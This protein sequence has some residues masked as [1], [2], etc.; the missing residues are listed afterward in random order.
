VTL[1][2]YE[3]TEKDGRVLIGAMDAVSEAEVRTRLTEK[4]YRVNAVYSNAP[5]AA[6]RSQAVPRPQAI[7]TSG[8][9]APFGELSVFF[10]G[11]ASYLHSG[12]VLHQALVQIGAQTPNRGMKII[13]DRMAARIQAGQRLSEAMSEFPRAFPPHV[14]G[15]TAAGELAGFLPIMIGDIAFNYELEQKASK[16][17]FAYVCKLGWINAIGT[18]IVSPILPFMAVVGVMDV[19]SMLT[20]YIRWTVPHI[21]L[22]IG[23]AFIIYYTA[24]IVLRQPGMRPLA[25]SLVLRVPAYGRASKE[26]SLAGFSRI[27]WRL[28]NAGILP[29]AAWDTASRAAENVVVAERLHSQLDAIRQGRKFSDALAATGMF[30][31]EDQRVLAMGE[32]AGQ[33]ADILKRIADF[34]EDSAMTSFGRSRWFATKIVI[35]VNVLAFA[36]SAVCLIQYLKNVFTWVDWFMGTG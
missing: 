33:T 35:W 30:T 6:P 36:F 11:L 20:K 18:I 25:H 12:V 2:K 19:Q 17:W 8:V 10:R 15:L 31:S 5:A 22:P 28:Q 32:S 14:V 34:Y 13:C 3:V 16:R 23:L 27:L 29:I 1:F 4:G 26:R 24:A 7:P 21:V 9:S